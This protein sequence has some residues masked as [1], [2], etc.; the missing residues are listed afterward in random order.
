MGNTQETNGALKSTHGA[1]FQEQAQ[2]QDS[3]ISLSLWTYER[4]AHLI[5]TQRPRNGQEKKWINKQTNSHSTAPSACQAQWYKGFIHINLW[6]LPK[7][8]THFTAE[9][10]YS[11]S[12]HQVSTNCHRLSQ[13]GTHYN[14][15]WQCARTCGKIQWAG[16]YYSAGY[17]AQCWFWRLCNLPTWPITPWLLPYFLSVTVNN[18]SPVQL[19]TSMMYTVVSTFH[20][21]HMAWVLVS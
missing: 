3:Q 13:Q 8:Q 7:R 1:N 4:Q 6:N 5:L 20:S 15:L 19:C 11:F 10:T 9:Q 21:T 14:S 2:C 17:P 16:M 18:L 12:K